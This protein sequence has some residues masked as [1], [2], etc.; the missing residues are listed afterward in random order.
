[1]ETLYNEHKKRLKYMYTW[2]FRRYRTNTLA[3]SGSISDKPVLGA[4]LIPDA[5]R[6]FNIDNDPYWDKINC[7]ISGGK[8]NMYAG[9]GTYAAFG[10]SAGTLIQ[11]NKVYNLKYTILANRGGGIKTTQAVSLPST[12]GEQSVF[13]TCIDTV[14]SIQRL[15]PSAI[16]DIDIDNISVREVLINSVTTDYLKIAQNNRMDKSIRF[17]WLGE[18]GSKI[19]SGKVSKLYDINCF[20]QLGS[21]LVVNSGTN[22]NTDWI[23][24]NSDGLA[25]D[26]TFS[27]NGVVS[28]SI[29]NGINGFTG[30]AQRGEKISGTYADFLSVATTL[31]IGKR[32]KLRLKY[33][34]L[35]FSQSGFNSLTI[36]DNTGDAVYFEKILTASGVNFYPFAGNGVYFEVDELSVKE[37]LNSTNTNNATQTTPGSRPYLTGNIAPNEKLGLK[38][39]NGGS[40]FMTHPTISFAANDAWS[41]TAVVDFGGHN[42]TTNLCGNRSPGNSNIAIYALNNKV[43]FVNESNVAGSS[44]SDLLTKHIGKNTIYN[45]VADGS[46]IIK[47]Y[48]NGVFKENVSLASNFTFKD[49]LAARGDYGTN[50][51]IKSHII[52]SIALTQDQVTAEYDHLRSVYPEI[53]SVV[54]GT[55]TW[56]TSNCEMAATPMGNVIAEMQA[57]ANV[58]KITNGNFSSATGWNVQGTWIIDTVLGKATSNGPNEFLYQSGATA[59]KWYKV[60]YTV[61][62]VTSGT[63]TIRGGTTY[64]I[65]RNSAGTYTEYFLPQTNFIGTHNYNAVGLVVDNVSFQEIGWSGSQELYDG[66]YA[67]TAEAASSVEKITV[68]AD[69]DFSSDTGWWTKAGLTTIDNA[70][71]N[72]CN[73]KTTDGSFTGIS[74]SSFLTNGRLY[75]LTYSI[76]RYGAGIITLNG[77][78]TDYFDLQTTIGTYTVYFIANSADVY[79]KRKTSQVNVDIDIDNVSIKEL[80]LSDATSIANYTYAAVKAAGFWCHYNNDV[81][82]GAIYGKLYN[83][84]AVKLLQMD[85]DYYNTANPTALWGWRVPTQADF[86]TLSD[87]LGGNAVS[88]GKLKL[89]GTT[90]WNSPNT[91][92]DNSS[93]FSAIGGGIR[94]DNGSDSLLQNNLDLWTISVYRAEVSNS[95][96]TIDINLRPNIRG[97]SL[98][99]T[100]A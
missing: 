37:V 99:L 80:G 45:F 8:I 76:T 98:R 60:T 10:R 55:Q 9:V 48:I 47:I 78:A 100:K 41:V 26:F 50:C 42:N 77:G 43:V 13:F 69:R 93:G 39:P 97:Y 19:E 12:V 54:I 70:D 15:Q 87:Y 83:W 34:K 11:I 84:F 44:T 52:R 3:D 89:A 62:S 86:Q 4:E 61:D 92:A 73:I 6:W 28:T 88:G 94:N 72:V 95:T 91:G 66:I 90:Y 64:G 29:I 35:G 57:A 49:I 58:E 5:S 38:N 22:G 46:G 24:S 79:I 40:N 53:E 18:A 63:F 67:Q 81:P 21:E 7:T 71:S 36:P 2:M 51:R 14:L 74:R 17:G 25:D 1:M 30:R 20:E 96:A 82:T 56:A 68:A 32:Y 33:R 31:V 75:K 65:T 27:G 23:D 59:N 16:T 85:I